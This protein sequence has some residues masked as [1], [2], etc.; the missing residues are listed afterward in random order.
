M[1]F[2]VIIGL[3]AIVL[4]IITVVALGKSRWNHRKVIREAVKAAKLEAAAEDARETV[5]TEARDA[6]TTANPDT[7]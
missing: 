5:L 6:R 4:L 7:A 1:E 2:P 3:A